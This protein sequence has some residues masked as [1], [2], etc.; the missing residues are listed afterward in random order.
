VNN[1]SPTN[2]RPNLVIG[3][4]PGIDTGVAIYDRSHKR[5]VYAQTLCFWT[6]H[7][8]IHSYDPADVELFIED[9]GLIKRNI[10][11]GTRTDTV[12]EANLRE[13]IA[14]N[15]GSNRREATLLIERFSGLA[16][17]V[18]REKPTSAK[19]TPE[20]FELYTRHGKRVSEHVRDAARLCWQR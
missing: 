3:I 11:R 12:N 6:A 4:D 18:H 8:L 9:P 15:I 20:Q 5:L 10:Y 19:W 17:T 14:G 16:Y 1:Q 7:D 13:K 2:K